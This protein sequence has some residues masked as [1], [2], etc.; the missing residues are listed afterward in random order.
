MKN[1]IRDVRTATITSKGQ[2]CIPQIARAFKGFKEGSKV[3]IVVYDN[4]VEIRPFKKL[5]EGMMAMLMSEKVLSKRWLSKEDEEA[6]K[7]L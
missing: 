1:E 4:R 6:W 2:V 3:S 5:S 7:D